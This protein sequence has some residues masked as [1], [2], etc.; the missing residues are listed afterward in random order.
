MATMTVEKMTKA[1][2]GTQFEKDLGNS[3]AINNAQSSRGWW[4]LI[5]SIR[6]CRLYSKGIKPHRNWRIS[7]VK[8]YFGVKGGAEA[9]AQI[10]EQ[11]RDV[12]ASKEGKEA[13][14]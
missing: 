2:A 7:D 10:L 3:I 14:K 5:L 4:N 11:Y 13:L 1:I 12:L 8:W 9:I 6:D